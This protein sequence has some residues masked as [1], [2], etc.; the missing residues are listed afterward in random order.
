[1]R[2]P[3][4]QYGCCWKEGGIM[5]DKKRAPR[6]VGA[7]R[8]NKIHQQA[9]FTKNHYSRKFDSSLLPNPMHY[10]KEQFPKIK[11]K[12]GWVQ[13]RC[14]FHDD[15]T[16]SLRINLLQG[17]FRCFACGS[18]GGGILT[19]HMLRYELTFIEAVN[20]FGAWSHG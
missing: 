6:L 8:A 4:Q 5:L 13:I 12:A 16:P 1:M 9:N 11:T 10:Y 20:Y 2:G 19:F 15:S 18:K 17:H 7:K 3:F 14:C